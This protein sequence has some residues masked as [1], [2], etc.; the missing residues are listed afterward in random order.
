MRL[1][2]IFIALIFSQQLSASTAPTPQIIH[3]VPTIALP[4]PAGVTLTSDASALH[5][6]FNPERAANVF[7]K[8]LKLA[9]VTL[10]AIATLCLITLASCSVATYVRD[11]RMKALSKEYKESSLRVLELQER[12]MKKQLKITEGLVGQTGALLTTLGGAM[13][14][15]GASSQKPGQMSNLP[16]D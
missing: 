4:A 10:G 14:N 15:V 7:D 12:E 6:L 16:V 5:Q 2:I 9:A 11:N 13:K 1:L 3:T 8:G